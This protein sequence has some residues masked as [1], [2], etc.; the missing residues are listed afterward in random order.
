MFV[1]W[2]WTNRNIIEI[3]TWVGWLHFFLLNIVSCA[4]LQGSWLKLIFHWKAQLLINV[5]SLLISLAEVLMSWTT[6]NKEVSSAN[7]LHSPLRPFGKSLTY[8]KNKR[9]PRME[10][11]GTQALISTQDQHWPFKTTLCFLLVNKSFS[12]LIRSPHI[13]FWRSFVNQSSM[14]DFIKSFRDIKE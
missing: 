6:E 13:P 11:C 3:H 2:S 10:P 12:I 8:I 9:G 7:N 4:Y 1:H 5:K 14:P